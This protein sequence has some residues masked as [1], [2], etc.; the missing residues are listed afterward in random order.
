MRSSIRSVARSKMPFRLGTAFSDPDTIPAGSVTIAG[1]RRRDLLTGIS[2]WFQY[3]SPD[4]VG[5]YIDARGGADRIAL[6][7]INNNLYDDR[8]IYP[9]INVR[10]GSGND[11]LYLQNY[12]EASVIA[13]GGRGYDTITMGGLS[14]EWRISRVFASLRLHHSPINQ[15]LQRDGLPDT[16]SLQSSARRLGTLVITND[17]ENIRYLSESTG[18]YASISFDDLYSAAQQGT[19]L[20]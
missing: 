7:Q 15:G 17:V 14:S 16:S 19:V 5:V 18:T 3:S 12:G 9:Y 20:P 8:R 13:S 2:G 6:G 1:T 4:S 10:L 11:E